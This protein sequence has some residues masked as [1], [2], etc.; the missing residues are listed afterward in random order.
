MIYN[1]KY[2]AIALK[3][4]KEI[5]VRNKKPMGLEKYRPRKKW[6]VRFYSCIGVLERKNSTEFITDSR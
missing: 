6:S 3:V 5:R 4:E 2:I 1:M